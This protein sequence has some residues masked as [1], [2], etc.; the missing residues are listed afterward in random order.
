[1]LRI[2]FQSSFFDHKDYVEGACISTDV[3]PTDGIATGSVLFEVDTQKV[4]MYD[5]ASSTW[6]EL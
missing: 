6:E 3:K 5:E 1:M 2:N 4:F